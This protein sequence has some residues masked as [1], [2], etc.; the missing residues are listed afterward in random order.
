MSFNRKKFR[1][2]FYNHKAKMTI[3]EVIDTININRQTL[4]MVLNKRVNPS[5]NIVTKIC[6]WMGKMP[7]DYITKY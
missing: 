7:E 3:K 2:D 4:Y 5:L 6:R 1:D